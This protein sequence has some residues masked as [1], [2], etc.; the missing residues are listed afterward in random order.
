MPPQNE[1]EAAP[2]NPELAYVRAK[3][4]QYESFIF[5]CQR[6][7]Q[8][9][10]LEGGNNLPA[11]IGRLQKHKKESELELNLAVKSLQH[12]ESVLNTT[13]RTIGSHEREE[14]LSIIR[15]AKGRIKTMEM[16]IVEEQQQIEQLTQEIQDNKLA[17][18]V[19]YKQLEQAM[20]SGLHPNNAEQRLE[21]L[22]D[23]EDL[24]EATSRTR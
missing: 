12:H 8:L 23:H 7:K 15:V 22:R 5:V 14:L 9:E 13:E 18:E 20:Q 10:K 17:L 4:K 19:F 6:I 24:L 3:I 11:K 16:Y 21:E 2:A 1:R